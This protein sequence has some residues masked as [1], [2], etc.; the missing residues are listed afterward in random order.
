MAISRAY[1]SLGE[2]TDAEFQHFISKSNYTA[3]ILWFHFF[4]VE[5]LIAIPALQ[6][7]IDAF[8]FK[9]PV[10]MSWILHLAD[11]LPKGFDAYMEW[12]MKM[13]ASL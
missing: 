10:L 8:A 1:N 11:E 4:I 3:R 2:A 6:P 13:L 7:V 12:P 9:R 5:Y